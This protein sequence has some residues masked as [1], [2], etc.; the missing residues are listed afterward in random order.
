[1]S[2]GVPA[3][4][5]Y[6]RLKPFN[7][8]GR[9]QVVI[10]T[11]RGCATKFKYDSELK[12]FRLNSILTAGTVFPY[13][14]G[15]VPG[16]RGEDGDPLDVLV[17]MDHSAFPG[18]IVEARLIGVIEA[19]Q[20]DGQTTERNDRLVA[21]ADVAHDYQELMSLKDMNQNLLKELQHFFVSYE[22]MKNIR[23]RVLG[24][25]GPRTARHLIDAARKLPSR[26]S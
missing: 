6:D 19:E 21:V 22:E 16:T 10:E 5:P 20:T 8:E 26:K 25:R 13:D 15:F 12:L 3:K 23:F 7:R 1:M 4:S 17:L 24:I 14:F 11:P 2:N 9:L 18:C